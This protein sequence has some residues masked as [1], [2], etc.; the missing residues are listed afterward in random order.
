MLRSYRPILVGGTRGIVP[1]ADGL[2]VRL[3]AVF[4]RGCMVGV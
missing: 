1:Q 4:I 2:A 3:L